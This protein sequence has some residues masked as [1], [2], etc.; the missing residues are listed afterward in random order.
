L[1]ESAYSDFD[2]C[3]EGC[4][5]LD[6]ASCV[7]VFGQEYGLASGCAMEIASHI[8]KCWKRNDSTGHCDTTRYIYIDSI[9]FPTDSINQNNNCQTLLM[10]MTWEILEKTLK[11]FIEKN[12]FK[13]NC[14]YQ[15][16][17]LNVYI[18]PCFQLDEDKKFTY[19]PCESFPYT[20][21]NYCWK[22]YLY[23]YDG[24]QIQLFLLESNT[25][26]ECIEYDPEQCVPCS[27]HPFFQP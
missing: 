27:Q 1:A 18:S 12:N 8:Q 17:I 23:C 14:P 16:D 10:Q 4:D 13:P 15:M 21:Y 3:Q 22:Q 20:P 25:D 11:C 6:T 24:N 9:T 26:N 7:Y 2:V 19:A 5:A